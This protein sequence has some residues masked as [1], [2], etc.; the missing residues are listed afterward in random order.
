[1]AAYSDDPLVAATT[2]GAVRGAHEGSTTRWLGIPYAAAP[3]GPLRFRAPQP[4]VSWEGIREANK[5]GPVAPQQA[6]KLIPIPAGIEMSEDCLSLNIWAPAGASSDNPKPVMLWVHGG[7]Y[8]IGF[9]AQPVYN[10]AEL[11]ANGDVVVVTINYRLGALGWLDFRPYETDEHPFEVNLGLK[12]VVA[13]LHWVREN[14]ANFGG[15]PNSVTLFGESAGAAI[16]TTLMTTPHTEGLFHRAIAESTPATSVYTE[17]H[18]EPVSEAFLKLAGINKKDAARQLRDIPASD[19]ASH[20]MALLDHVAV[21]TP[22]TVAFAP[23]IDG[24]LIAEFPLDVF[25][26]GRQHKIPLIVGSNRDEAALFKMMKS[27]LMPMSKEGVQGMFRQVS[28]GDGE[29]SEALEQRITA[30]YPKFP[31]Q[32][33][34]MQISTDAGFRMP[35]VWVAEAHSQHAPTWMYR[36]D[37]ATPLFKLLGLGAPH[38]MELAYVFGT[39]PKK[40]SLKAIGFELGGLK[41]A[42][43][44]SARMQSRWLAFGQSGN[45]NTTEHS[46]PQYDASN[47][48]TLIINKQDAQHENPMPVQTAA[49]GSTPVYIR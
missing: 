33:G 35:G 17:K 4:A 3:L 32:Q 25:R 11:A 45:P 29:S 13:A 18:S 27:P 37:Q 21:N 43:K 22:G 41:T 36:F 47:R 15:D 49:W 30:A 20:T 19:L 14:I 39:L 24:D 7:A 46:W 34:C 8:F 38:S 9:S 28:A 16:V 42:R 2:A 48:S 26:A 40:I 44:I 6:N 5:F 1:M 23:L 12:D 10:G 31:T